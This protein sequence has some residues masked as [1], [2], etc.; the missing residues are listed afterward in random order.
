MAAHPIASATVRLAPAGAPLV[1]NPPGAVSFGAPQLPPLPHP[2]ANGVAPVY[3]YP[4]DAQGYPICT[5]LKTPSQLRRQKKLHICEQCDMIFDKKSQLTEHN[6]VEHPP[7]D[8]Y[9]H[10]CEACSKTF[11]KV[12]HLNAHKRTVHQKVRPHECETCGKCFGQKGTLKVHIRTVGTLPDFFARASGAK[13]QVT[14]RFATEC[15][16]ECITGS[17]EGPTLF[18]RSLQQIVRHPPIQRHARSRRPHA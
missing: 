18:L 17:S 7:T 12:S 8:L 14:D 11:G 1:V 2:V 16:T 15:I 6:R 9:V 10:K 3:P 13:P 4:L 5:R